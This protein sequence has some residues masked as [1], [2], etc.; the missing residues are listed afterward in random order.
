M[1]C[2]RVGPGH[3]SYHPASSDPALLASPEWT[4]VRAVTLSTPDACPFPSPGPAIPAG[5]ASPTAGRR[6]SSSAQ[7]SAWRAELG[8]RCTAAELRGGC[9]GL[10]IPG[11]QAGT[12][13]SAPS[14]P[15]RGRGSRT[16]ARGP[17]YLAPSS[18]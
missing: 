8:E 3:P 13:G 14:C 9:V 15:A 10:T 16:C 4:G 5:R 12:C 11:A 1:K 18:W 6:S 17:A 2:A 7:G